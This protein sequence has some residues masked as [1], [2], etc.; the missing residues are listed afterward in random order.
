M[1]NKMLHL[2]AFLL[3]VAGGINWLLVG[4]F[5]LNLVTRL[6]GEGTVTNVIYIVI[7]L[8]AV[9]ELV[10]HKARCSDCQ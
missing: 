10:T 3:L 1:H 5:N 2:I 8:A 6:L 4:T 9:L 7:G